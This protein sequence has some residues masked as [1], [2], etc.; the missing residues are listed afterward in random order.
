MLKVWTGIVGD[1]LFGLL[2]LP[3]PHTQ[4]RLLD[5]LIISVIRIIRQ[6]SVGQLF[7]QF[8]LLRI[9]RCS[10]KLSLPILAF[11][12]L[13]L[14]NST[15]GSDDIVCDGPINSLARSLG[16]SCMDHYILGYINPLF[17]KSLLTAPKTV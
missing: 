14:W 10:T 12:Y 1:C 5:I 7:C 11:L 15:F 17:R 3:D 13:I 16:L 9:L 4:Y 8:P 2:L 6:R